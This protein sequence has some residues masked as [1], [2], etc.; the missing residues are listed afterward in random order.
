MLEQLNDWQ[1]LVT[2]V[3][4]L[5][6]AALFGWLLHGVGWRILSRVARRTSMVLDDALLAHCR[7]PTLFILPAVAVSL[8]LP[9][10]GARLGNEV[11]AYLGNA[12]MVIL[13]LAGAWL[14]VRLLAVAEAVI[15]YR[16]D[17][18]ARD[19]LRA[20]AI[21]TQFRIVR[22]IAVVAIGRLDNILIT[23]AAGGFDADTQVY[24]LILTGKVILYMLGGSFC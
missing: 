13:T 18:E 17:V 5:V 9:W 3:G 1:G 7:R 4:V 22:R 24:F 20:R 14:L 23:G 21:H 11:A 8:A 16:F 19:N 10:V 6:A 15:A 12:L 2:T